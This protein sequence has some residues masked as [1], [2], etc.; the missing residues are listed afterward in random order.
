MGILVSLL[1]VSGIV[2]STLPGQAALWSLAIFA[3]TLVIILSHAN[4]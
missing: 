4:Q 2:V 1:I 3:G